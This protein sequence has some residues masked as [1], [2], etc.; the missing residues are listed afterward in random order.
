MSTAPKPAAAISTSGRVAD[1]DPN[2][3][4]KTRSG[5]NQHAGGEQCAPVLVKV[6][7]GAHD[8]QSPTLTDHEGKIRRH[9]DGP[10]YQSFRAGHRRFL[11]HRRHLRRPPGQARL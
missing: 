8:G 3:I 4:S 5:S 11:R 1:L 7:H 6:R 9:R 2:P 10:R